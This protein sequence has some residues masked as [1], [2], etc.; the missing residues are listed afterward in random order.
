MKENIDA[1]R[2]KAKI[3]QL[4]EQRIALGI[5]L[6]TRRIALDF[7]QGDV[8]DMAGIPKSTIVKIEKGIVTNIDYYIEYAK[9]VRLPL[10]DLFNIKI[11][12]KPR[13]EL[14]DK[15]KTR[16]FLSKKIRVLLEEENFFSKKTTVKDIINR[17]VEKKELTATPKLSAEISGV[18]SNWVEDEIILVVE[19]E[20]RNN[21]YLKK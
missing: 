14:S 8:E 18:L 12:L 5:A 1:K 3:H 17:L 6:K 7:S 10:P 4:P 15:K 20:G 9:T 21:V 2:K 11:E 19:K 16:V 13:F